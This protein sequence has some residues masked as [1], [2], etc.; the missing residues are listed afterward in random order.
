MLNG[1]FPVDVAI[2]S[3]ILALVS[4]PYSAYHIDRHGGPTPRDIRVSFK[5]TQYAPIL[6]YVQK[7]KE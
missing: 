4:L 2:V 1:L 6:D 7:S 5:A 3:Y